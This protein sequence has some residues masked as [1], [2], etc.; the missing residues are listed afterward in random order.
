MSQFEDHAHRNHFLAPIPK[1]SLGRALAPLP[2]PRI[3]CCCFLFSS[4]CSIFRLFSSSKALALASN[5][6][7]VYVVHVTHKLLRVHSH[8]RSYVGICTKTSKRR[9]GAYLRRM[10]V[11]P[12]FLVLLLACQMISKG[13]KHLQKNIQ[14]HLAHD[15]LLWRGHFDRPQK[16]RTIW[17]RKLTTTT[18]SSL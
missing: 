4:S 6:G 13:L 14:S 10:A 17:S 1:L 9:A 8:A 2:L 15:I 5:S 12:S 16:S 11:A 18:K 3:A 7:G